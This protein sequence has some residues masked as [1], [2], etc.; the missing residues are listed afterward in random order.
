ML[1]EESSLIEGF[2]VPA[3]EHLSL[4]QLGSEIGNN[5][6][7]SSFISNIEEVMNGNFERELNAPENQREFRG[8]AEF[9]GFDHERRSEGDLRDFEGREEKKERAE[10]SEDVS[11]V[12]DVT[13][14]ENKGRKVELF[15][16]MRQMVKE[17]TLAQRNKNDNQEESRNKEDTKKSETFYSLHFEEEKEE[18]K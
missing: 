14:E 10:E 17:S 8:R 5:Q 18:I 12:L 15:R 6:E 16:A 2:Q 11:G 1:V 9:K 7:K 4:V 3:S 13:G